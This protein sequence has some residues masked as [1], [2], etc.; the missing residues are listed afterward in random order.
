MTEVCAAQ[1]CD[2]HDVEPVTMEGQA[3]HAGYLLR[4]PLCRQHRAEMA[5]TDSWR[6]TLDHEHVTA[7]RSR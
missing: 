2:N 4:F 3:D 7:E 1:G 6:F 5:A